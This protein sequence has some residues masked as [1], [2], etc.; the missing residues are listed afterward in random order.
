MSCRKC[1]EIS[2][3]PMMTGM[4]WFL[5]TSSIII[6]ILSGAVGIVLLKKLYSISKPCIYAE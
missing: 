6:F 1:S 5:R 4:K 2:D 3:S